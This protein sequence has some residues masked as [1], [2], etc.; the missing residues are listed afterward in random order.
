MYH[1]KRLMSIFMQTSNKKIW[2]SI[3]LVELARK[4]GRRTT[5][6]RTAALVVKT[7]EA[8][9]KS[10]PRALFNAFRST[11]EITRGSMQPRIGG[12]RPPLPGSYSYSVV[13]LEGSCVTP[14]KRNAPP[15]Y[16]TKII[17]Q[18]GA[19]PRTPPLCPSLYPQPMSLSLHAYLVS[20][21]TDR[22]LDTSKTERG[23]RTKSNGDRSCIVTSVSQD[24]LSLRKRESERERER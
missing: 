15:Q 10:L 19:Q 21:V 18:R 17:D 5:R 13:G 7:E 23:G 20:L 9:V 2:I 12:G 22:Q 16:P 1:Y 14:I 3:Q 4:P 11:G 24:N 8:T 6:T